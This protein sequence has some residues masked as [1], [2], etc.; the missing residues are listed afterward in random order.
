MVWYGRVL[1]GVVGNHIIWLV[2]VWYDM[3]KIGY[4]KTSTSLHYTGVRWSR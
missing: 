1:N 3:I 4:W 2:V